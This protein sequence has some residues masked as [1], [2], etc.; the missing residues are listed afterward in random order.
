MMTDRESDH[1]TSSAPSLCAEDVSPSS[2]PTLTF[3]GDVNTATPL[4]RSGVIQPKAHKLKPCSVVL[5]PIDMVN[6]RAIISS[7]KI[8]IDSDTNTSLDSSHVLLE[9]P[10]GDVCMLDN[11]KNDSTESHQAPSVEVECPD[12]T[13]CAVEPVVSKDVNDVDNNIVDDVEN[14]IID[15]AHD[16]NVIDND[17]TC[18]NDDDNETVVV[19]EKFENIPA[20][21]DTE[22]V[23]KDSSLPDL[24]CERNSPVD[25][26][27]TEGSQPHVEPPNDEGDKLMA[28]ID[29]VISGSCETETEVPEASVVPIK[30]T[31]ARSSSIDS[32]SSKSSDKSTS[33]SKGKKRKSTSDVTEKAEL[34]VFDENSSSSSSNKLA[35]HSENKQER[36]LSFTSVKANETMSMF[37]DDDLQSTSEEPT[38]EDKPNFSLEALGKAARTALSSVKDKNGNIAVQHSEEMSQKAEIPQKTFSSSVVAELSDSSI[39]PNKKD[40]RR[41]SSSSSRRSSHTSSSH[42]KGSHSNW[43]EA[44][45][46]AGP[47]SSSSSGFD[48]NEVNRSAQSVASTSSTANQGMALYTDLI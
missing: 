4:H 43:M 3:S 30:T 48:I 38:K 1:M 9:T 14:N 28:L 12:E 11:D 37:K 22:D 45:V 23:S 36:T 47:T 39:I 33:R 20:Q 32:N 31:L 35:K 15:D 16:N 10:S 40:P 42:D 21:V 24:T 6:M 29:S 26:A 17:I 44:E 8:N 5:K 18:D 13:S 46:H 34:S 41:S 25:E 27:E 19:I 2:P 7:L